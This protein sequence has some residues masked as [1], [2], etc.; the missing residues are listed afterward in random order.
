MR[1]DITPWA[2]RGMGLAAGALCVLAGTRSVL[3]RTALPALDHLSRHAGRSD[4]AVY[5]EAA[6]AIRRLLEARARSVRFVCLVAA[7]EGVEALAA[8]FPDVHIYTA[9]VDETMT[10]EGYIYPGLGDVGD[11]LFG[12]S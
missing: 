9:A 2:V 12:T 6:A 10:Q 7:R 1:S 8:Q 4:R 11:R 3:L 5:R